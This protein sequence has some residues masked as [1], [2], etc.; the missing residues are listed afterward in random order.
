MTATMT[1]YGTMII[2]GENGEA[3]VFSFTDNMGIFEDTLE[4]VAP[5]ELAN[6]RN[7]YENKLNKAQDK[8]AENDANYSYKQSLKELVQKNWNV[9]YPIVANDLK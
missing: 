9:I 4:E 7:A 2:T 5:E 3:R 6:I 8:E 1:F